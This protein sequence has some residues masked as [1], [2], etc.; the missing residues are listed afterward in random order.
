MKA[1]HADAALLERA[2]DQAIVA[3][4]TVLP[5]LV[6]RESRLSGEWDYKRGFRQLDTR[7][8]PDE[9]FDRSLRRGLRVTE[10]N[11][12]WRMRVPLMQRWLRARA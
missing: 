5:E 3:A 10:D 4:D 1:P 8:P 6:Q 11:G 9:A 2:L 12:A 7:P